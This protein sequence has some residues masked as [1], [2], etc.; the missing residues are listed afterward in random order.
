[1]NV[2]RFSTLRD[3]WVAHADAE[4]PLRD[5]YKKS[6]KAAWNNLVEARIDFPHADGV[7]VASGET[8][9]VFNIGGNKYRLVCKINYVRFRLDV[10]HILTHADYDKQA[11]KEQI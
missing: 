5:W 2:V 3:F 4:M 11:W 7:T 10:T 9:T 8:A 1:M 6:R